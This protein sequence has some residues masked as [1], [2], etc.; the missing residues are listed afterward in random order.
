VRLY[1]LL[2]NLSLL[3]E[4]ILIQKNGKVG[5]ML[6]ESTFVSVLTWKWKPDGG[7]ELMERSLDGH[8]R[9]GTWIRR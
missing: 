8:V 3:G 4:S 6:G 9:Y 5:P 2:K 1:T 7:E